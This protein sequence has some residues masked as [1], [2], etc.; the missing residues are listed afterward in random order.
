MPVAWPREDG[1]C[2]AGV[3]STSAGLTTV[4]HGTG[5]SERGAHSV[6]FRKVGW[7]VL[8]RVCGSG[9]YAAP[10]ESGGREDMGVACD[11]H[12]HRS[13]H[14]L[15]RAGFRVR[16]WCAARGPVAWWSGG[17]KCVWVSLFSAGSARGWSE[18]RLGL[19]V[20][21]GFGWIR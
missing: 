20:L 12:I 4:V 18:M 13:R 7:G 15:G 1:P 3:A 17:P 2:S 10:A 19:M 14:L 5:G 6:V 16:W 9:W 21:A 11:G 8:G